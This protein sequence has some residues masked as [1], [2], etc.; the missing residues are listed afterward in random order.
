MSVDLRDKAIGLSKRAIEED[1]KENYE[2]AYKLYKSAVNHFIHLVKFESNQIIR[3]N[4]RLKATEFMNRMEEIEKFLK[5]QE[6]PAGPI[7]VGGNKE[8]R[9][10]ASDDA[11]AGLE[12][13][14]SSAIVTTKPNVSWTDVAGLHGAK[15]ALKEA[16]ILPT[17]FPELF[18]GKL[19]PW[20]GIL[21]YG[22]PGTGKSFLAKAC[23][24]ECSGT[25]FS[26]SA[27]DL[28]AKFMGESERLVRTLFSMARER[29]PS[30]IFIDE[31]DSLCSNR[32]EGEHDA[33]RRIK[34]EFLVQMQGVGNDSD[35]ILVLGATNIP[36]ELDPAIRRRF[37]RRVY[38]PLPDEVARAELFRL[39]IGDTPNSLSDEDIL[40]LARRTEFFSGSDIETM[41]KSALLEPV[42][43]CS[44]A[45]F[46]RKVSD[47]FSPCSPS[48]HGA[49]EMVLNDVPNGKLLPPVVSADDFFNILISAKPSVSQ[50]DLQRQEEFTAEFGM[51]GS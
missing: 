46:F 37:E 43:L 20:K 50:N 24:T 16:V 45:R 38:I 48:D 30:I 44:R 6:A 21:L 18:V 4:F 40:E 25:F 22:P 11:N 5:S 47:K 49:I 51:E 15:E 23:A 19:K 32:S 33:T 17:R 39:K 8:E 2:E 41:V 34:T 36:W 7:V 26:A 31:I 1:R 27:S 3:D 9:K 29:K 14:L 28:V 42:R 10:N 13:A 12:A 35:G